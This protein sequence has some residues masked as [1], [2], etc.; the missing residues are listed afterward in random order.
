MSQLLVLNSDPQ[1]RQRRLTIARPYKAGKSEAQYYPVASATVESG[2]ELTT[3][4]TVAPRLG[5]HSS[6]Q[7][8]LKRRPR[9]KPSLRDEEQSIRDE[10]Q[11]IRD[12][13]QSIRDEEQS[14]RDEEQSIRDEEQS[15]RDE[16]QSR[17]MFHCAAILIAL[18]LTFSACDRNAG[19][20]KPGSQEYRDLVAAFYVGLA[21]LQTGED[22]RAKEKLTRSTEIAPGEP[23]CWANL[24]LLAVRQQEFDTAFE[25]VEKARSLA[26]DN[27][28]IEA[29]LG[30]IESRRGKLPEAAAHLKKAVE[31][32]PK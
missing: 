12:E 3:S 22:V 1:P 14:I 8:A 10:E 20:P 11:S 17:R 21:G 29:L 26:P 4:S 32:D 25:K 19:L 23:A 16:E 30:L 28:Q 2:A 9:F 27:S 13:E 18:L 31:L 15:I 5:N 24:G 6:T 7:P